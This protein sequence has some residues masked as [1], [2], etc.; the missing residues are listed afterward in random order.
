MTGE[1]K[2]TPTP[3]PWWEGYPGQG[4]FIDSL[5]KHPRVDERFDLTFGIPSIRKRLHEAGDYGWVAMARRHLWEVKWS[6]SDFYHSYF[7]GRLRDQ[8]ARLLEA[9]DVAVLGLVGVYPDYGWTE[10]SLAKSLWKY[11]SWGVHVIEARTDN[12]LIEAMATAYG[13]SQDTQGP[14]RNHR[15]WEDRA[16]LPQVR[17]LAC[18]PGVGPTIAKRLAGAVFPTLQAAALAGED[19]YKAV[20]GVGDKLAGEAYRFWHD[21]L[22]EK[23]RG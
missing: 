20:P 14:L 18:I 5:E 17:A 23:K 8:L 19:E 13:A 12:E 22:K 4:V 6:A 9:S 1:T 11:R 15:S 7:E 21:D 3:S 2:R 10:A 16:L